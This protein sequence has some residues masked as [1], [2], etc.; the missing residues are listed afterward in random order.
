MAATREKFS[1]QADP[2]L[3]AEMRRI[4]ASQGRQFQSIIEEAFTDFID[5]Q[6]QDKPRPHVMAQFQASVGKNDELGR[7]LAQ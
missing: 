6:K 2:H 4:A 3:L 1:T 7:L 5:K